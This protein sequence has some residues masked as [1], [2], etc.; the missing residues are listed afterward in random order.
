MITNQIA[1]RLV[2][3]CRQGQIETAQRELFT[4]KQHGRIDMAELCIY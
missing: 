3:L 2:E 4:M 1:T